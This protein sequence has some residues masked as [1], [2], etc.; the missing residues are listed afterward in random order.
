MMKSEGLRQKQIW[1]EKSMRQS[2]V[3]MGHN[4]SVIGNIRWPPDN[5]QWP[6]I[7]HITTK[8]TYLLKYCYPPCVTRY[9]L[10]L[11][12][13]VYRSTKLPTGPVELGIRETGV[14]LHPSCPS[15]L[16][17]DCADLF[18]SGYTLMHW[19]RVCH[20]LLS[21]CINNSHQVHVRDQYQSIN[22]GNLWFK[23]YYIICTYESTLPVQ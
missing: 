12:R 14:R 8:G 23:L 2:L 10:I 22:G 5:N 11:T 13:V 20:V 7:P 18:V 4:P 6:S 1:R 15:G 17:C 9:L 16:Y 19:Y 21:L 3:Y